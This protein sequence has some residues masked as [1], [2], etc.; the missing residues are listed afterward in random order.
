MLFTFH[1]APLPIKYSSEEDFHLHILHYSG[2]EVFQW[3][4][5]CLQDLDT[6]DKTEVSLIF[7]IASTR[8]IKILLKIHLHDGSLTWSLPPGKIMP[9]AENR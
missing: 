4:S 1:P 7:Y 6:R 9:T 3:L 8:F 5:C 2:S